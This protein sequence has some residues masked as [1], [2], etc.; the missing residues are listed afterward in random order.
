MTH[1]A[2]ARRKP[3]AKSGAAQVAG[4]VISW[5]LTLA[6]ALVLAASILF[7]LN[8]DQSKSFFGFRIYNVLTKSMTP[9]A[10]SPKGGFLAGD[11]IIVKNCS[12]QDVRVGDVITFLPS[13]DTKAYLTH[14]VVKVE[15]REGEIWF[16]TRGDANNSDD[17]AFSSDLLIG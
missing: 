9:S 3:A 12:A 5:I 11:L 4:S 14:R 13:R 6:C 16:T 15:Q 10:D 2:S 7:A 8:K 1:S 17:P